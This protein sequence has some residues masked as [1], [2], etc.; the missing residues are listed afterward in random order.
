MWVSEPGVIGKDKPDFG[1]VGKLSD[2]RDGNTLSPIRS[3][4]TLSYPDVVH[5]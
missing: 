4:P 1:Y 2:K 5:H 3:T